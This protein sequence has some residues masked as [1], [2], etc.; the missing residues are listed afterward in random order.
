MNSIQDIV[1][2][3]FGIG[4]LTYVLSWI[5]TIIQGRSGAYSAFIAT[6][7]LLVVTVMVI[8]SN[9]LLIISKLPGVVG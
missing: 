6:T 3:A 9:V 2:Y 5:T 4:V 8:L 1:Q 7:G